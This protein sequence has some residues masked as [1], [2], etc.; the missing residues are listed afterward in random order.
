MSQSIRFCRRQ[1]FKLSVAALE[2]IRAPL[3]AEQF[4]KAFDEIA[5]MNPADALLSD[6]AL[7]RE[8]IYTRE[9]EWNR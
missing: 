8:S 7:S 4:E 3:T 5:Q 9:D 1:S 2:P 6:E